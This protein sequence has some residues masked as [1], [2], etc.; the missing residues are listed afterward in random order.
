MKDGKFLL[1]KHS[2]STSWYLAG[3]GLKRNETL[4]QGIERE[5]KEELGIK[6]SDLKLHGVYNNFFEGK[7]DSIIVF[8]PLTSPNQTKPAAKLKLLDILMLINFQKTLLLEHE[9]E[10]RNF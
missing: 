7:S 1:V 2:Y 9:K 6:V 4:Q 8:L 3:G 5:L 10:F